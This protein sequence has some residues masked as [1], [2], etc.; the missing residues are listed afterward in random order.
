MINCCF[1]I[2]TMFDYHLYFDYVQITWQLFVLMK[3]YLHAFLG[4]TLGE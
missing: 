1:M 3:D 2:V 4:D